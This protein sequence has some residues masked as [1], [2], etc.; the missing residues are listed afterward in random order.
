LKVGGD[1]YIE[2]TP[3]EKYSDKKLIE[4]IKPGFINGKIFRR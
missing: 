1:L 4:M 3:L 2:N